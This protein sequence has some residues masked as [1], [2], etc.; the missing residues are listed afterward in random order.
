M[1]SRES[2]AFQH[3]AFY[4][5]GDIFAL[6]DGS[7][8]DFKNLFPLDDLNRIGFF[9]KELSDQCAAE[10]ITLILKTIDFD[11]VFQ[12]FIPVLDRVYQRSNFGTCFQKNLGEVGR[13]LSKHGHSVE[14]ET[15]GRSVNQVDDI[16]ECGAQFVDILA[17]DWC[18]ESLVELHDDGVRNFIT[19]MLDCFNALY[20]LVDPR[21][22][23]KQVTKSFRA[24][25]N[26]VRLLREEPKIIVVPW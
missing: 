6:I 19:C 9:I 18:N 1:D 3:Y 7:L 8:Y 13:A 15:T 16:V 26:I 21:V 24:L 2:G 17:V 25:L 10:T 11:A 5:I 20:L 12:G 14:N 4:H 22:I 23:R